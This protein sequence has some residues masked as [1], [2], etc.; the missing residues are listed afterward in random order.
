M[1]V[2]DVAGREKK[3]NAGGYSM[4]EIIWL[5]DYESALAKAVETKKPVFHDF[6]FDG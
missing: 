5:R 6:W 2:Y 1:S 4:G 3:L